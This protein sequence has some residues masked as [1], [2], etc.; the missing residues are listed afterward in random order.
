M[1]EGR[2]C[3]T[4]SLV[5]G[6]GIWKVGWVKMILKVLF[7]LIVK[8]EIYK[9]SIILL[10]TILNLNLTTY[11]NLDQRESISKTISTNYRKQSNQTRLS[12]SSSANQMIPYS[13]FKSNI[14]KII[15]QDKVKLSL[16][17]Q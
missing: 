5:F 16:Y 3:G 9:S 7:D 12:S 2:V 4:E 17:K 14:E 11:L 10:N 13:R 15:N 1:K 8:L 6:F